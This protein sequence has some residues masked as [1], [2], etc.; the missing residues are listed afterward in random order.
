VIALLEKGGTRE[1]IDFGCGTGRLAQRL[2]ERAFDV[3]YLG[4]DIDTSRIDKAN[5]RGLSP[6]RFIF[7]SDFSE[8]MTHVRTLTTPTTLNA[9]FVLHDMD[10]LSDLRAIGAY[11]AGSSVIIHDLAAGDL[12]ALNRTLSLALGVVPDA[13]YERR[14]SIYSLSTVCDRLGLQIQTLEPIRLEVV[15]ETPM[16][17]MDYCHVF[18]VLRGADMPLH[19]LMPIKRRYELLQRYLERVTFPF[20]DDRLFVRIFGV[21]V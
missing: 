4:Y 6:D 19:T 17:L 14:F 3:S 9:S 20:V 2:T 16:D 1:L 8:L 18:G 13:R 11:L 12:P 21:L 15:F 5:N 10:S 7:T